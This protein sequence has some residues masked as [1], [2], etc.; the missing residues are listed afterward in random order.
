MWSD[1]L[2]TYIKNLLSPTIN[3]AY[4]VLVEQIQTYVIHPNVSVLPGLLLQVV[5]VVHG[6]IDH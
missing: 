3:T 2:K 5:L 1:M 4:Q 6:V